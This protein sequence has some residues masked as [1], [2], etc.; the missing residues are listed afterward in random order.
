MATEDLSRLTDDEKAALVALLRRT[1]D[2]DRYPFS[3]RIRTPRGILT[4]LS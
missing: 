3:P 1:V 4:K 2:E